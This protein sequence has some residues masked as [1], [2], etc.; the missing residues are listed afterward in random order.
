M[1]RAVRRI[2]EPSRRDRKP[3]II[4]AA[5]PE[6]H[7][8][9]EPVIRFRHPNN[10]KMRLL[11]IPTLAL[12]LA[13][14]AGAQIKPAELPAVSTRDQHQKL[15]VVA[16]PYLS[17]ERYKS[18]FGKKTPYQRGI[19]AIE[20]YFQNGNDTPIR[21]D[22]STIRLVVALP[23]EQKQN[24]P[25]LSPALPPAS[26]AGRCQCNSR[27]ACPCAELA[28]PRTRPCLC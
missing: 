28:Q 24:L 16:D 10:G 4:G 7:H 27:G 18:V 22:L 19:V 21:V 6:K 2:S 11:L 13:P 14:S 23:G 20:V 1:N 12:L 8:S 26:R 17:A 5:G 15:L 9:S 25:P 3:D